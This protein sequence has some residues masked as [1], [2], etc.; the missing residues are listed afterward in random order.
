MENRIHRDPI[1]G[2]I[3]WHRPVLSDAGRVIRAYMV[4]DRCDIVPCITA[5]PLLLDALSDTLGYGTVTFLGAEV[6]GR[7]VY[8]ASAYGEGNV[9]ALDTSG[10][11]SVRG[12]MAVMSVTGDGG[13]A[14]L[15]HGI[16]DILMDRTAMGCFDT[17]DGHHSSWF[18]DGLEVVWEGTVC[19]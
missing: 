6:D 5:V 13:P 10:G 4:V 17:G 16:G 8:V 9:V 18:V 12:G 15:D 1:A 11:V 19:P 7:P 3:P 14:P 2:D